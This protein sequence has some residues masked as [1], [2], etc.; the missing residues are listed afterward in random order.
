M[1]FPYV[2]LICLY[3]TWKEAISVWCHI[4]DMFVVILLAFS[5]KENTEILVPDIFLTTKGSKYS[6]YNQY[7]KSSEIYV[8][9]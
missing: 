5:Q 2:L 6:I 9:S 7:I 1:S 4:I 3:A 8:K